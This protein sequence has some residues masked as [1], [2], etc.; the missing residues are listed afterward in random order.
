MK[1][2]SLGGE[3]TVNN[4]EYSESHNNKLTTFAEIDQQ[5]EN[6]SVGKTHTQL[7]K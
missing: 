7:V 3:A 4:E 1:L 6:I 5:I 2:F